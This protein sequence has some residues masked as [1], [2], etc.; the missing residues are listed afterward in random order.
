MIAPA[1]L[2]GLWHL[3]SVAVADAHGQLCRPFGL[4]PQGSII[5]L[6][7]GAMAVHIAGSDLAAGRRRIYAGSWSIAGDRVVHQVETSHEPELVGVRLERRAEL[8][9][10]VLVYRTVEAQ[11]PGHPVVVWTRQSSA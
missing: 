10:G 5:Y 11:G 1:D 3:R 6:A 8:G 7:T 4:R 9:D 2:L